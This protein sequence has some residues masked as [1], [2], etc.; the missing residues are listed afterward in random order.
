MPVQILDVMGVKTSIN[1]AQVPSTLSPEDNSY[2]L[3]AYSSEI[4]KLIDIFIEF[5][6]L[7][8]NLFPWRVVQVLHAV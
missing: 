1:R 8:D 6:N 2:L 3:I 4:V 7:L 5:V